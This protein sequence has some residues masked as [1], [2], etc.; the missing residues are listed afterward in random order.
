[1][2][3]PIRLLVIDDDAALRDYLL[4]FGETRGMAVNAFADAETA[5][6]ALADLH[7]DVITLDLV[8]PGMEG[9]SA[10]RELRRAAPEVPVLMLS[11]HGKARSIVRS[12][13]DA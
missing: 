10:L 7:P 3:R 13:I 1:M 5:I 12:S 11:G 8:L 4:A 2:A 6:A 9:L